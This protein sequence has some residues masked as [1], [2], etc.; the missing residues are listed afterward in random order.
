MEDGTLIRVRA[1]VTGESQPSP[2]GLWTQGGG[3]EI[4]CKYKL[5]G[6]KKDKIIFRNTFSKKT[7]Q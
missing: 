2:E 6:M 7:H 1:E 4:P 3:I 5:N